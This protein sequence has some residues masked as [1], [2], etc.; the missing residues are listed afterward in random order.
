MLV[1]LKW[2]P[3]FLQLIRFGITGGCAAVVHFSTVIT[4]VELG[5]WHPLDANVF[6][7]LCSFMVSFTGHR[8]WTFAGTTVALKQQLPTFFITATAG[9]LLNQSLFYL[10]LY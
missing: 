5:R 7:F 1:S 2:N 8:L 6:A 4:L 10:L 3:I 9:F